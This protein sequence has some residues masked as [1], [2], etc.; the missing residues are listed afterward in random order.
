M[1][2]YICLAIGKILLCLWTSTLKSKEANKWRP[3][4]N[5]IR[6]VKLF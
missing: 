4:Y 6:D 3:I 1:G 2:G 5:S